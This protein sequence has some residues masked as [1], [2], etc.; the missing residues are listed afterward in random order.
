M[1]NEIWVGIISV[2]SCIVIAAFFS[3]SETSLTTAS[4]ARLTEMER[5]GSKRAN[6]VLRLTNAPERLIGSILLG[7][8]LAM[9]SASS[10]ATLSLTKIF[11]EYGAFIA[12]AAMASLL[13]VFAE[14]MPKTYAIAYPEAVATAVAPLMRII[15]AILGP[16]VLAVEFIVKKTLM[17]FGVDV[18]NVESILSAHDELRGAIDL[19][20]K[21]GEIVKKD[22]DMLG[23]LLDLKDLEIHDVMVHR[24]KMIMIDAQDPMSQIVEDVL[25]SGK[26]RLPVWKDN[27]DNIIGILH[28]KMLFQALQQ[29][30]GDASKVKI[31]HII[32]DPWFVPDTRPLEDQLTAFLRRK[33]HFAIVVDEYGELQGLVTLE[34]IIEE[35]VGDI[36][37]EFDAVSN[38]VRKQKDGSYMVDGT[39]P[40]RDLNRA[41]D[42]DLP[43]REATTLA[44]MVIHEARMIPDAGQ[45]F[46][47]YGFRFEVLKKR[48]QQLTVIKV[49][50]LDTTPAPPVQGVA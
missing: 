46:N 45:V 27:Q 11:G 1:T 25:K 8:S 31:D 3:A 14:V 36:E 4:R 16:L 23:G 32:T 22:R 13:L 29:H 42:W 37:D 41:L 33:S 48:K 34:D 50:R 49:S 47:F 40:L 43:D 44:G 7:S 18:E 9:V 15:T 10:L 20:H 19:H 30:E 5:R 6:L 2:T 28:A 12:S 26:T 24:T 38:G 39:V 35:I 21:E 17:L